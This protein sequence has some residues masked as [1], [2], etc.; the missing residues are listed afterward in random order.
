MHT[1]KTLIAALLLS[2]IAFAQSHEW[3]CNDGGGLVV[4]DV[5]TPAV[6]LTIQDAKTV[7]W[8]KDATHGSFLKFTGGAATAPA[9]Q[10]LYPDGIQLEIRF[11]ADLK[12]G[13]EWL[14][15][16]T[17]GDSFQSGYSVWVRNNG[18]LLIAF[19]GTG[20]TSY[21]YVHDAGIRHQQEHH[22]FVKRGKGVVQVWLDGRRVASYLND[23][24]CTSVPGEPFRLGSSA[25]WKYYGDIYSVHI[26][27]FVK[28]GP[29]PAPP[30][31]QAPAAENRQLSQGLIDWQCKDGTGSR[32]VKDSGPDRI[33][34][35]I[36]DPATVTWARE[37]DRGF[38]L[39]FAGG[40]ATAP[41]TKL[42][43]PEGLQLEIH[44]AADLKAGKEW[45]P[46]V[47]C[48][49]GFQ[50][51]YSAWVRKNGELLVAFPGCK[52]A[53]KYLKAGIEHLR[54]TRLR[55]TRGD[56]K[57]QVLLDGKEIAS[58]ACT[59]KGTFIPGEPFH[60]GSSAKWKFHGNIYSVKLRG[61]EKG[62]F[63]VQDRQKTEL[64]YCDILERKDI[65]D[66]EGTVVIT[67]FSKFSPRPPE[68]VNW[69]IGE[70]LFRRCAMFPAPALGV[71]H[72]SSNPDTQ[73]ISYTP[74]LPG[75]YD[76][77]LG[78]RATYQA[79]DLMLS[80]PG[81][82]GRIRVQ[83][84]PVDRAAKA[85]PN[86]EVLV[87]RDVDLSQG[88]IAFHPGG[89]MYVGYIKCI[90]A[91]SRRK[92]DYPQWKS[93]TV[94]RETRTYRQLTDE[95]VA[96]RIASGYFIEKHY[97]DDKPAPAPGPSAKRLGCIVNAHDWMDLLFENAVPAKAPEAVQLKVAAAPGEYEPACLAVYGL[98]DLAR[99]SLTG[100]EELS[101]VGIASTV[102]VVRMLPKRTTNIY[103][104]S[105]FMHSPQY[106]ERTQETQVPRGASKQFWLTFQVGE[107]V[108]PGDY[109]DSFTLKTPKGTQQIP[110]TVTVRPFKLDPLRR[111]LIMVFGSKYEQSEMA[112]QMAEHGCNTLQM[113]IGRDLDDNL[114]AS[115]GA[116]T[117]EALRPFG[118]KALVVNTQELTEKCYGTPGGDERFIQGIR[119]LLDYAAAHDWPQIYFYP[120]DEVLSNP[121]NLKAFMWETEQLKKA[122]AK[123]IASHIW[124]KTTRAFKQEAETASQRTDVFM[125]R[126]NTRRFWYVDSWE[127]MLERCL[128]EGKGLVSYNIDNAIISA[129]PAMKRFANGW[130]FRTIGNGAL[131]QFTFHYCKFNGSPY[132][133]LDGDG[134]S[135]DWRYD[136]PA[137]P[138]HKGG[139]AI[140]FE[141]IREGV[142]DLKYITTLE[143]RI[144]AARRQGRSREADAAEKV[145]KGL[146]ASFDLGPNF[147]R[148][149]VYLDSHYEKSWQKDGK[150]YCSGRYNLPNGWAFEDY[151]NARETIAAEIVKLDQVL[152]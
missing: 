95:K 113:Y 132:T 69:R 127:E 135:V 13:K 88:A 130:F 103:G 25:K 43:F 53:N 126:F 41:T 146:A 133:D 125:N 18:Q 61:Y 48:G 118:L 85:H 49:D 102:T 140:D 107:N 8:G 87:A 123:I 63:A 137:G 148:Q 19:P 45:L 78:L 1:L 138:G 89:A 105:E 28:P 96:A 97:V 57:V 21:K 15:L 134:E 14:P 151:H 72:C 92:T 27:P 93:V 116:K 82:D 32:L 35:T 67:D 23:G 128:K 30:K 122:G 12:A 129:Q 68:G 145:L 99:V 2:S 76:V 3:R 83:I 51:G 64:L 142:D 110:V 62:M 70:W 124:Y 26:G 33:H 90:P 139:F 112:R 66:P 59:G 77:Y 98:E 121:R 50:S 106:L 17:C 56:G 80:L 16:V 149:S 75:K 36:A 104:P 74:A 84:L 4:K 54:D 136:Y 60:L 79:T 10:L 117:V 52:P 91:A 37:D 34:L 111:E 47:T 94:T 5:R 11:A 131:G 100:G 7:A 144:A 58:Y 65:Q 147:T 44:F 55:I 150:R 109:R 115:H 46:L 29:P 141:A 114:A 31:P 73:S 6:N 71:L 20:K 9:E 101:K 86:T 24:K 143:N 38:F 42:L 152:K 120:Y 119:R 81:V 108:R 39:N 40:T 22:L